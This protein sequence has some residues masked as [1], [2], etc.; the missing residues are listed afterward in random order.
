[1]GYLSKNPISQIKKPSAKRRE[2][3]IKL[4]DWVRIRD[5]YLVRVRPRGPATPTVADPPGQQF[6]PGVDPEVQEDVLRV[7]VDDVPADPQLGGDLLVRVTF[8]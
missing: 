3:F 4:E 8:E 6:G 5:S 2:Q 1:M 7:L